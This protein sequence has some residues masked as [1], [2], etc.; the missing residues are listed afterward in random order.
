MLIIVFFSYSEF[1]SNLIQQGYSSMRSLSEIDSQIK[2]Q[3]E[4]RAAC[5]KTAPSNWVVRLNG[6]LLQS[7]SVK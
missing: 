1:G 7:G 4:Y 3:K 5:G 2:A 6:K